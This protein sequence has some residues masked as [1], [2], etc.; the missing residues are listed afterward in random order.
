MELIGEQFADREVGEPARMQSANS[1]QIGCNRRTVR[2]EV[3]I[4]KVGCHDTVPSSICVVQQ[5]PPL[6]RLVLY[7]LLKVFNLPPI[8]SSSSRGSNPG[9]SHSPTGSSSTSGNPVALICAATAAT[10][11]ATAASHARFLAL[12]CC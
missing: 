8:P 1:L 4:R 6:H 9:K 5:R 10:C 12:T 2:I 7:P 11:A 3:P